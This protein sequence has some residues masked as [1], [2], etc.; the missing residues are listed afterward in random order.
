M[1]WTAI[2]VVVSAVGIVVGIGLAFFARSKD[3][4]KD[5]SKELRALLLMVEAV[6][7]AQPPISPP[8][9]GDE[10]TQGVETLYSEQFERVDNVATHYLACKSLF[11]RE[12]RL[13]VDSEYEAWK[14][15]RDEARAALALAH[16]DEAM[17]LGTQAMTVGRKFCLDLKSLLERN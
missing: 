11:E 8:I 1:N 5:R 12:S 3:D 4:K 6:L 7:N 16:D 13:T 9:S 2:G 10:K 14:K 15:K 17:T